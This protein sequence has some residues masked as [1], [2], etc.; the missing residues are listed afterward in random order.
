MGLSWLEEE[1]GIEEL[2][3][4][5]RASTMGELSLGE[6]EGPKMRRSLS[7]DGVIGRVI[8][9]F[10]GNGQSWGGSDGG[11]HL[12]LRY[13]SSGSFSIWVCRKTASEMIGIP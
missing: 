6:E 11:F 4:S 1:E 8:S 7:S 10:S 12:G 13:V 3:E 9:S 2:R 5:V